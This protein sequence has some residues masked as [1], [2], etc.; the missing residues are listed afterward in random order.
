MIYWVCEQQE[1]AFA[2]AGHSFQTSFG[3]QLEPI[4]CQNLFCVISKYARV[5]TPRPKVCRAE[6]ASSKAFVERLIPS[7]RKRA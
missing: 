2:D 4:D 6:P 5:A 1:R 7:P 3:R